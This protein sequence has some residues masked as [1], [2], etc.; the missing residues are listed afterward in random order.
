MFVPRRTRPENGN[1]YFCRDKYAVGIIPGSPLDAGCDVLANCVGYAAGRFNEIIGLNC[2]VHF[3]YAPDPDQWIAR[4][5]T[6]GLQTG[7][8]PQLG[9][10]AVWRH[11]VAVVEEIHA[12]GSIT[13]SESG[14]GCANPFWT[15]KRNK[16]S[17]SWDGDGF[18][19]FIY[20]PSGGEIMSDQKFGIDISYCQTSIDWSKVDAQFAIIK[21]GQR[22]YTDPMFESHYAGATKRGIPVGAY[23]FLDKT[24]LTED[25]A[26]KEADEFIARLRGKQFAYPVFLDL[27]DP[28]HFDL[29]KERVSALIRAFLGRVEAA[30]FWVGLYGSY[31]SLTT[32]TAE[33]IRSRYTIWLAHWGV[34]KSPYAGAYGIWQY[35]VEKSKS[36]AAWEA[37]KATVSDKDEAARLDSLLTAGVLSNCSLPGIK[38][39]VD[40][41][42]CYVDYP[43]LI[44]EKGLNG[45][46][47]PE[48]TPAPTP[49]KETLDITME[50]GGKTYSGTL[51]EK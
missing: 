11:H 51:T 8:E 38:G 17:G 32:Y 36:N 48:P 25:A 33:D 22:N 15:S 5:R 45:Y 40:V 37:I 47:K 19:G 14:Y 23:W 28:A 34:K 12:D 49:A 30:G 18:L 44:K 46:G 24:S 41:D 13:T 20:Q 4:A 21:A 7:T 2:F 16:G 26:R 3:R 35:G 39:D 9:A 27:E 50:F 10:V 1:P 6:E 31:S 42:Y 43:K 29:G